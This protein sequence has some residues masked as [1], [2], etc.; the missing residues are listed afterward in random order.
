MNQ[1]ITEKQN[2]ILINCAR[3]ICNYLS[4]FSIEN[5]IKILS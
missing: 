5:V 2:K 4:I 1:S 3:K